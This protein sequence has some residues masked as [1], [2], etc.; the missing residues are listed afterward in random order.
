MP[1]RYTCHYWANTRLYIRSQSTA[2]RTGVRR[3]TSDR[4]G[5]NHDNSQ[6][7]H[8]GEAPSR[9]PLFRH[10]HGYRAKKLRGKLHYVG[11][12]SDDPKDEAAIN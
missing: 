9:F 7:Y 12:I 8:T 10:A 5:T 6:T 1:P 4:E 3:C 2:Q 11:T